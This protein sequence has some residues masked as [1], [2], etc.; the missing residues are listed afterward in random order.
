VYLTDDQA[1]I[2]DQF[3]KFAGESSVDA[4]LI[5]GDI[6]DRAIPP[7]DAVKLLDE[8][9]SKLVLD[10]KIPVIV[11]PGNHDSSN[12]LSFGSRILS[13]HGLNL[14]NSI[15]LPGSVIEL[16]DS[17]G[18][19]YIAPVPFIEPPLLKQQL[20]DDSVT[21]QNSA[22]KA[23]LNT[24]KHKIPENSRSIL[25]A[26]A[27]AT[28]GSVSD[29]ERP[30][31]VGTADEVDAENFNGFDYVALGHLHRPQSIG[32]SCVNYSGSLLKYSF[33]EVSHNKSVNLVEMD[34]EGNCLI[35]QISLSPKHDLRRISGTMNE[36]LDRACED[37]SPDDYLEVTLTD[38]GP[39][40]N[41][42]P[43]LRE[44]YKNVLHIERPQFST[45]YQ[46]RRIEG[47]VRKFTDIDLFSA[48]Y[49][50]AKGIELP[51]AHRD[52]FA[53]VVN[54][55]IDESREVENAAS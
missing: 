43:R 11:I 39:V 2:L 27:F 26:H 32:S 17:N 53:K 8:V 20:N 9:F 34:R 3:V 16:A 18:S 55:I 6:F 13:R 48:F 46:I 35:E 42:M 15:D 28:G 45:D 52:V 19:V 40:L 1:Y 12:R 10:L 47:D 7:V 25:I 24:I 21:N 38:T 4:I 30:I 50:Q 5:A 33:S 44:V 31:S 23:I 37:K 22:L 49:E 41:A 29:S 14:I 51:D 54:G 36:L